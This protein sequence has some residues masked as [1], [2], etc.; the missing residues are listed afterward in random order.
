MVFPI[1]HNSSA[2]EAYIAF[3]INENGSASNV[4]DGEDQSVY[5]DDSET[6]FQIPNGFIFSDKRHFFAA[7]FLGTSQGNGPICLTSNNLQRQNQ[8]LSNFQSRNSLF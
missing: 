3:E 4:E 2:D 7:Q 1:Q 8:R 6:A 5:E